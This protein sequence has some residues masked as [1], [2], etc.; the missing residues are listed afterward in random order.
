MMGLS[1]KQVVSFKSVTAVKKTS[2]QFFKEMVY[3]WKIHTCMKVHACR[4]WRRRRSKFILRSSLVRVYNP[5][6]CKFKTNIEMH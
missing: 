6:F 3:E 4:K 1:C 5:C 2:M